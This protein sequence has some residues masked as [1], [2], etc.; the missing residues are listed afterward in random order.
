MK[1]LQQ[2]I[3]EQNSL[4]FR[5][6]RNTAK[7]ASN[8]LVDD[9]IV[10]FNID[11]FSTGDYSGTSFSLSQDEIDEIKEKIEECILDNDYADYNPDDVQYR[12]PKKQ[13]GD[14]PPKIKKR[15]KTSSTIPYDIKDVEIYR[16]RSFYIKYVNKNDNSDING[17]FLRISCCGPFGGIRWAELIKNI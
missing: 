6:N 8:K 7:N 14:L 10:H 12:I 11:R 4:Q 17:V 9:I 13:G 3:T 15:Y 1:S 2:H 16:K 5:I